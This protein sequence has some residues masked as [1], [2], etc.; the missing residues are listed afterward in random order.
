MPAADPM[1]A[2]TAALRGS[3]KGSFLSGLTGADSGSRGAFP[4]ELR[5]LLE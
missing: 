1:E 3:V 5:R 4:D 2:E